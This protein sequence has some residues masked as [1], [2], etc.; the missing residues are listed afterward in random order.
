MAV[1]WSVGWSV[2]ALVRWLFRRGSVIISLEGGKFH[3][4]APIG[5]LVCMHI[6][7]SFVC[8][9]TNMASVFEGSSSLGKILTE[10]SAI[11]VY[12]ESES[13]VI[14]VYKES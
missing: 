9:A 4:H 2:E 10:S 14:L 3:L 1:L 5:A 6:T 11:H 8:R 12:R 7:C 13:S